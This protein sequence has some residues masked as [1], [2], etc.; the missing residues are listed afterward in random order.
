MNVNVNASDEGDGRRRVRAKRNWSDKRTRQRKYMAQ[1]M[2][3]KTTN[4]LVCLGHRRHHQPHRCRCCC[5]CHRTMS[6]VNGV[7]SKSM[8]HKIKWMERN[9]KLFGAAYLRLMQY[10]SFRINV[11]AR[12][13]LWME[14]SQKCRMCVC[15]CVCVGM[16]AQ[17][18]AEQQLWSV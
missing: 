4:W 10:Y 6:R 7:L 18:R 12:V 17:S 5:C 3:L 11:V 8:R 14:V 16:P 1:Y 13:E 2:R 9:K 15:V